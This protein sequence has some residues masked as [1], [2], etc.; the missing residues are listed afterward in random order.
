M[1]VRNPEA[2]ATLR[3]GYNGRMSDLPFLTG[4]LLIAMPGLRDPDFDHTVTLICQHSEEGA[5]GLVI[6]RASEYRMADLLR[7]LDLAT[8]DAALAAQPVLLGGPLQRERGFV[9]HAPDGRWAASHA[10]D[11]Q[12]SLTTSRD[13]LEALAA[14]HGPPQMLAALGYAGWEAGQLE[15]E[16][17]ENAWLTAAADHEIL[18]DVPLEQRWTAAAARMGVDAQRLS[19]YAGNA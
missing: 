18:F 13:I 19:P 8:G 11:A 14:G 4:Q 17:R 16:L 10:I 9:L 6:N 5:L 2:G 3:P 7:H 12:L 1:N 15:R